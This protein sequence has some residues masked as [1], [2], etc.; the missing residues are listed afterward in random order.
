[1]IGCIDG[2]AS[3]WNAWSILRV[4]KDVYFSEGNKIRQVWTDFKVLILAAFLS[5]KNNVSA[6]A[7]QPVVF[8]FCILAR[9]FPADCCHL[10]LGSNLNKILQTGCL[11]CFWQMPRSLSLRSWEMTG[12]EKWIEKA[13]LA[14]HIPSLL[15][16]IDS[17]ESQEL[18]AAQFQG[19]SAQAKMHHLPG[20]GRACSAYILPLEDWNGSWNSAQFLSETRYKASQM[21]CS[22]SWTKWF[23]C[24]FPPSP[25]CFPCKDCH[26]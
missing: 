4:Y 13:S 14:L 22:Q 24:L 9:A 25:V 21:S 15:S 20:S 10:K 12:W 6:L 26:W 3:K 18:V 2:R 23:I 11:D 17:T 7:E 8:F 5:I 19:E 1:M 16:K